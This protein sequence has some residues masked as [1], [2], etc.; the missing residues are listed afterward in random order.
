MQLLRNK[1]WTNRLFREGAFVESLHDVWRFISSTMRQVLGEHRR[2]CLL[3][4]VIDGDL[5]SL[6]SRLRHG[7]MQ[8]DDRGFRVKSSCW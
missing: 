6:L 5:T 8:Q 4:W 1:A 2:L 7:E 3:L